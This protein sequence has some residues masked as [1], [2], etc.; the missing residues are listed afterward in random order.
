MKTAKKSK[1]KLTLIAVNVLVILGLGGLS[2]YFYLEN[3]DLNEQITLTTEQK[4]ARL[5]AEVNEVFD[6]PDEDP[7]VAIVTDA[8]QFKAEYTTFKEARS[9]DHLLF[10]RKACLNVL[11][12][13]ADKKVLQT[14]NPVCPVA[15]ELIGE[16]DAV[17]A[18]LQKLSGFGNQIAVTQTVSSDITQSFVFDVD[19]DQSA[20]AQ[21]VADQLG[22]GLSATLPVGVTLGTQTEIVIAVSSDADSENPEE[23]TPPEATLAP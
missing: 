7:V 3:Q 2:A 15:V 21:S 16:K 11:Y 22:L 23:T 4:N 6:L 19:G 14:A 20:E 5:V 10:F 9:G 13:Q 12:R 8:E 17:D 18:A 1:A